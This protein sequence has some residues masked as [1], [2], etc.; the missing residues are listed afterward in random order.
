MTSNERYI[1]SL[2]IRFHNKN[3][4]GNEK[5]SKMSV[6]MHAGDKND[7]YSEKITTI[8][9]LSSVMTHTHE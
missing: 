5:K 3:K 2:L 4:N 9:F 7:I 1:Y 8:F 6:H